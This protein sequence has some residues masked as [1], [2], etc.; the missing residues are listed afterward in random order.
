MS[1]KL[2]V[3][4]LGILAVMATSAFAVMNASANT[5]A[6]SHFVADPP[7]HNT[8]NVEG[9]ET[10]PGPHNLSFF[11]TDANTQT[12]GG[13]LPIKCTHAVYKGQ[14][15]GA[16]TTTTQALRVRPEYKEC[17]TGGEGPHNIPVHVPATCGNNVYEFTSGNPGTIHVNCPITITHPNCHITVPAQTVSGATYTNVVGA[18]GKH[19]ITVHINVQHIT[20]HFEGGICVFLGTSHRFEMVGSATVRALSGVAPVNVTHT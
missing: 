5:P 6:N 14:L 7:N 15:T 2:R 1:M 13:S 18:S 19:E 17:S 11:R 12:I 10:F 9:T 8:L 16:A 4:G 20:G 3:L